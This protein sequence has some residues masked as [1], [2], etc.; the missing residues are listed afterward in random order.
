MDYQAIDKAI[1]KFRERIGRA[2]C[3]DTEDSF[4][5]KNRSSTAKAHE[6]AREAEQELRILIGM[7]L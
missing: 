7:P 5:D 4:N 3:M 1:H 6:D 2:W